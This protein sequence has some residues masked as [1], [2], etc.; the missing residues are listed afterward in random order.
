MNRFLV[1][2]LPRAGTTW[3]G[4]TL[5]RTEG[6]CYVGEPDNERKKPYAIR[7]KRGLGRFPPLS[8]GDEAQRLAR[9]WDMAFEGR[10]VGRNWRELAAR[11]LLA[12]TPSAEMNDA[13]CGASRHRSARL[14]LVEALAPTPS[15]SQT[16]RNV[17]VK[18]VH[19][20]LCLEWIDRRY[21]PQVLIVLRHPL[22][23]ISS[24]LEL[25]Y[26]DC[27]LEEDPTVGRLFVEPLGLPLPEHRA[28]SLA[29]ISWEVGLLNC[30]L[31]EAAR[32]HPEW[33]IVTHERLCE[34]PLGEFKRLSDSLGLHW[35]EAA[36]QFVVDSNRPGSDYEPQ[37]V[38][39]EQPQR[40]RSR[41]SDEQ[42]SEIA[43]VLRGFPLRTWVDEPL[44]GR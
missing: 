15:R 20:P 18:S 22:N 3:V 11:G 38:A 14:R 8:A 44:I 10:V 6:A 21:T 23:T 24:W 17:L 34:D 40:W 42:V 19:A 1:V 4:Q 27:R 43:S 35:G 13:F 33:L 39:L 28:S 29:R 30:V 5:G 32:K 31:E 37:R 7:A 16:A 25:G 26:F 2:G 12:L 41:L 9:L 36:R